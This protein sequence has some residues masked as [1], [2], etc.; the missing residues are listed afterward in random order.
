MPCASEVW[1]RAQEREYI[2]SHAVGKEEIMLSEWAQLERV[3]SWMIF[4]HWRKSMCSTWNS[5]QHWL[6]FF[7]S[8]SIV[9][10]LKSLV[11]INWLCFSFFGLWSWVWYLV[12]DQ[13][14]FV[15]SIYFSRKV[16]RARKE[17]YVIAKPEGLWQSSMNCTLDNTFNFILIILNFLYL[18]F[19]AFLR[20]HPPWADSATLN[21]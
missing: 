19:L 5:F 4:T 7:N 15:F 17:N 3:A 14:G 11:L 10:C 9:L 12:S 21:F 16:R 18:S 13:I 6:C 8:M 1:F 2:F 20:I